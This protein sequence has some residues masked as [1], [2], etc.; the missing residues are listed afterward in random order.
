MAW[1]RSSYYQDSQAP[2][3]A[4]TKVLQ[5]PTWTRSTTANKSTTIKAS[6]RK[7]LSMDHDKDRNKPLI[8]QRNRA[9]RSTVQRKR[10]SH[11]IL[12]LWNPTSLTT[13]RIA[14]NWGSSFLWIRVWR[15]VGIWK[16]AIAMIASWNSSNIKVEVICVRTGWC[17]V[18]WKRCPRWNSQKLKVYTTKGQRA[19]S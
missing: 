16:R 12:T 19:I 7:T 18:R 11:W 10:S 6:E 9:R 13:F 3:Q 2:V 14:A 4:T 15:P 1:K 8:Q 17:P 5:T